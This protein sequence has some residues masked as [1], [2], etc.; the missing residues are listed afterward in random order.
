VAAFP[1]IERVA[2]ESIPVVMRI[3][4]QPGYEGLVGRWNEAQHVAAIADPANAY[5]V[6]HDEAGPRGFAIV[7]GLQDPHGNVVLKRI[8]VE[9]AGEGFGYRFV[10]ALVEWA[11]TTTGA[12]R[13]W[14]D[15][16]EHND[17]AHHVYRK[18]GFTD[19][20]IWRESYRMPDGRR[21]SQLLMAILRPEWEAHRG[22]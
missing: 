14:L 11:F 20:G 4:R 7:G 19:D 16:F 21:V 15:L 9:R 18:V 13:V 17:R 5:L 6:G 12:H 3:E 10:A 22:T 1:R 2:A 8:A